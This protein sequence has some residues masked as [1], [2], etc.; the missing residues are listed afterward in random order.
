ME[1]LHHSA[2]HAPARDEGDGEAWPGLERWRDALLLRI[3][4][5]LGSRLRARIEA[6][7][8]LQQVACTTLS[9]P[10]TGSSG[11]PRAFF[12]WIA[13]VAENEIRN[14]SRRGRRK[15]RPR[16]AAALAD[17]EV[18]YG[19][20]EELEGVSAEALHPAL[21]RDE[22]LSRY[23]GLS[24]LHFDERL[25]VTIEDILTLSRDTSSFL[26]AARSSDGVRK[27]RARTKED[28]DAP[29][30]RAYRERAS[31]QDRAADLAPSIRLK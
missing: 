20:A 22:L 10:W 28:L 23:G 11:R 4:R 19:P 27:L 3:R 14:L 13:R 26:L 9:R 2:D 29:L 18:S 15:V 1:S 17:D 31:D 24:T 30:A 25:V 7:D 21:G 8:V 5:R 16:R 6:E 12:A